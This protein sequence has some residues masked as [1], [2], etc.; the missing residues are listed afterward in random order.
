MQFQ[1]FVF[2]LLLCLSAVPLS[3]VAQLNLGPKPAIEYVISGV[4]VSGTE[5]LYAELIV[6]VTG[7]SVGDRV[8][9]ENDPGVTKAIRTMSGQQLFS[10][11][12]AEITK[13]EG[14]K[15]LLN[16]NIKERPR[17]GKLVFKNLNKTQET[18]I[19]GKLNTVTFRM[20]TPALKKDINAIVKKYFEDKGYNNTQ[21]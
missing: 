14:R 3:S 6:A 20:V 21:V 17:L 15:V 10:D 13:I 5:F 11:I 18:E 12:R 8:L 1:R 9:L 19:R 7:L 2:S 16:F 4:T